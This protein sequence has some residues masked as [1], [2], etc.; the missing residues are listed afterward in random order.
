[1][2]NREKCSGSDYNYGKSTFTASM[3]CAAGRNTAGQPVDACQGDSGGPLVNIATAEQVGVVSWGFGCADPNFPG[4]YTDVGYF[5][6]WIDGKMAETAIP[7]PAPVPA[8]SPP[9]P[10]TT[11]V[12]VESDTDGW[13]YTDDGGGNNCL[14]DEALCANGEQCYA[15]HWFCDG[16]QDCDDKSDEPVGCSTATDDYWNFPESDGVGPAIDL[17]SVT[18]LTDEYKCE[19]NVFWTHPCITNEWKCDGVTDCLDGTDEKNCFA[20]PPPLMENAAEIARSL[21]TCTELGW[22]RKA[23]IT[24]ASTGKLVAQTDKNGFVCAASKV[25]PNGKCIKNRKQ[26][27]AETMC[28]AL[29]AR[30]CTKEEAMAGVAAKTGCNFDW[31]W[32]WTSHECGTG[33]DGTAK[34]SLV[35][36][37]NGKNKCKRETK[38]KA[39]RCCA[40]EV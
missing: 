31:K 27:G 3:V 33:W 28:E 24:S 36:T 21:K 32:H 2:I 25:G 35:K 5:K 9:A 26:L 37:G 23:V 8:P 14:S 10:T 11:D 40:D 19:N 20:T 6:S 7:P 4:V 22:V 39:V 18:C 12:F 15:A 17:A 30:L 34:Y 16:I 29:G 1:M 38:G 13:Y